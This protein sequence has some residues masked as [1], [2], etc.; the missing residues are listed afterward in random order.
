[1]SAAIAIA[2][3]PAAA[4]RPLDSLAAPGL[5]SLWLKATLLVLPVTS[6]IA[7]PSVQGTTPANLLILLAL[8]PLAGP[9]LFG[10]EGYG[11]LLARL[12]PFMLVLGVLFMASRFALLYAT[13]GLTGLSLTNPRFVLPLT[14]TANLTQSL[15]LAVGLTLFLL[16]ARYYDAGWDSAIFAG[17]WFLLAYGFIDWFAQSFLGINADLLSNRSFE[18]GRFEMPGSLRQ[19]LSIA[20]LPLL[21]FKS[22]TGEPSM[23]ALTAL[24]YLALAIA[25]G[26]HRL[27]AA[28]VLALLL[29][30]SATA[31][32]GLLVYALFFGRRLSFGQ[33]APAIGLAL[34]AL[35]IVAWA[36]WD[37]FARGVD[38]LFI[39]KLM[40]ESHSGSARLHSLLR[41]LQAW[42]SAPL[43][44]LVGYG[45]GTAR[46]TDLLSTLL[47]NVGLLGTIGVLALLGRVLASAYRQQ[48]W[49][50]MLGLATVFG[51]MLAAV[52]E[53]AYLPPWLLA[54]IAMRRQVPEAGT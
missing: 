14:M 19:T 27:A 45:F 13:D 2:P 46:S 12:L 6:F 17:A 47:V 35:A 1:M 48:R 28:L 3:G 7:I 30:F 50:E 20:G 43:P 25:R 32:A 54:G 22:F 18:V 42:C 9:L 26:R 39:S 21:R 4:P 41:H 11:R 8:F 10:L 5:S 49:A 40:G 15:Y 31:Y 33:V 53:F 16:A 37:G 51:L 44:F 36:D 52:P 23:F 24:C 34:A 38:H 29:S